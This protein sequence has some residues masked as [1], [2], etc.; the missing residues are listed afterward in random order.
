LPTL[1][2]LPVTLGLQCGTRGLQWSV[3]NGVGV[4]GIGALLTAVPLGIFAARPALRT[5]AWSLLALGV[6]AVAGGFGTAAYKGE[7]PLFVFSA[8]DPAPASD[9]YNLRAAIDPM[10]VVSFYLGLALAGGMFLAAG[11]FVSSLVRSQVVAFLLALGVSVFFLLDFVIDTVVLALDLTP[12]A[13]G[14]RSPVL[15][16][17]LSV[18]VHFGRDLARGVVPTQ[19]LV[20][21]ASVTLFALFL[22]VRS[23]ESQR[24]R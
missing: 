18:P 8:A 14:A 21:Y 10:P 2:Y 3:A 4:A 13:G 11:L 24:W 19:P 17:W 15:P 5:L 16:E 23:L 20:L 7:P 12:L 22:T 1:L 6:L 9:A